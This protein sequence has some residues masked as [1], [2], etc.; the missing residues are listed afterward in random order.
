MYVH[1]PDIFSKDTFICLTFTEEVSSF[2]GKALTLFYNIFTADTFKLNQHDK[3][4]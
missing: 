1:V 4:C 3:L 2:R